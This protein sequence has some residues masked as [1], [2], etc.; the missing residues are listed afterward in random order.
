MT[1]A[2]SLLTNGF[3]PFVPHLYHFMNIMK[4][5]EYELWLQLDFAYIEVCEAVLRL[6]GDSEGADREEAYA[7]SLGIPIFYRMMDLINYRDE[8]KMPQLASDVSRL[9]SPSV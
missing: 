4:H 1:V 3:F 9:E 5:V 7:K 8:K 2:H 6:S